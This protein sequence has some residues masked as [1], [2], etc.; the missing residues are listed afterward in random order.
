MRVSKQSPKARRIVVTGRVQGVFYRGW[1]VAR[2]R[3]LGVKGWVRN[4][5]NGTVEI[6]ACGVPRSVDALIEA[7]RS[8]PPAAEV[9]DLEVGD[10]SEPCPD[11]FTSRPT[12]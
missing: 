10:S 4:R 6:L 9:D 3:E 2:A 7:C 11:D 5:S 12:L 8:G 1:T